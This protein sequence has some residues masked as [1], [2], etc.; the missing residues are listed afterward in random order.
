MEGRILRA[1][2]QGKIL[3]Y[4]TDTIYGIGVDA[5]NS[6]AVRRL[7]GLKKS[8]K[9][10]SVIANKGWIRKNCVVPEKVNKYL[11]LLPGNYTLILR[12]KN[13]KA[14]AKGVNLSKETI[15]VRIPKH[16]FTRTILKTKRPFITTS[17]NV[18]GRKFAKSVEEIPKKFKKSSIIVD[19]GRLRG[20]P[21]KIYDLTG[22][23]AK[24]LR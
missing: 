8:K 17:V 16:P 15:G 3:I 24:R 22:K 21:S 13:K 14:I 5:T 7:R 23:E 18:S 10:F 11:K 6:A 12:L 4:P 2:K 1:I 19:A 20:N 9:P